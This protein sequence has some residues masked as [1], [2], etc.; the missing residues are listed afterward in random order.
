MLYEYNIFGKLANRVMQ[1]LWNVL[2][3]ENDYPYARLLRFT[4]NVQLI[5]KCSLFVIFNYISL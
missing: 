1:P 5:T 4:N 3:I 2:F